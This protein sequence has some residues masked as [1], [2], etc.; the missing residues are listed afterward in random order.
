[1]ARLDVLLGLSGAE[2]VEEPL[3]RAARS[4]TSQISRRARKLERV[5]R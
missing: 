5:G 4:L 3:V 2:I 1:M